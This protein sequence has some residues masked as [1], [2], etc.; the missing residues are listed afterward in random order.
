MQKVL[1]RAGS[2]ATGTGRST[3]LLSPV[4]P[5]QIIK[6]EGQSMSGKSNNNAATTTTTTAMAT[7]GRDSDAGGETDDNGF[8]ITPDYIQESEYSGWGNLYRQQLNEEI[9]LQP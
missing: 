2:A 6:F 3:L 4:K 9:S 1:A 8:K 7:G 5:G